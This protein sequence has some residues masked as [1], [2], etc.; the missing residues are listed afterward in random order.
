MMQVIN[1]KFFIIEIFSVKMKLILLLRSYS[2]QINAF[3]GYI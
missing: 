2:A 1:N 3:P